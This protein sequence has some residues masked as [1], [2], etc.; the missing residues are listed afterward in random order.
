MTG[1]TDSTPSDLD[2]VLVPT[3]PAARP[4]AAAAVRR[5]DALMR[6]MAALS[7]AAA[8]VA[9]EVVVQ[10][11]LVACEA[12][13]A[14]ISVCSAD[15]ASSSMRWLATVG[16]LAALTGGSMAGPITPCADVVAAG[17][18]L[19][20]QHPARRY[21]ALG[22]GDLP[23]VQWLAVPL[24]REGRPCG[25]LWLAHHEAARQ[26]DAADVE[27]ATALAHVASV[28]LARAR[29]P[30]ADD[31]TSHETEERLR[32][33]TA[34]ADVGAWDFDPATG[35]LIWDAAVKRHFGLS[36]DATVHGYQTFLDGLH[37]EDRARVDAAVQAALLPGSPGYDITYRT[38]GLEDGE[39]RHIA[40]RGRA[41]F[42][43]AGRVVR[44]VGTTIDI[45]SR[46]AAS[47]SLRFLDALSVATQSAVAAADVMASTTRLLGQH[48]D[49]SRCAWADVDD[50]EETYQVRAEWSLAGAVV[51]D[52]HRLSVFGGEALAQLRAGR[53]LVV[54]HAE[55]EVS[56]PA[57]RD[58]FR[59][60]GIGAAIACPVLKGGRLVSL[61]VVHTAKPRRWTPAEVALLKAVTERSGAHIDRAR[62]EASLRE[63][64]ER[65]RLIGD[66]ANDAIWDW[67]LAT[68][69]VTW[70]RGLAKTFGHEDV[71][72][73]TDAA[74][75]MAHVH[76]DDR[77]HVK[78]HIRA[79]IDGEAATWEDEYRFQR[80][81]GSHAFVLDRGRIV[82]DAEGR[83]L[84]MVG[85]MQDLTERQRAARRL[86]ESEEFMRQLVE[87]SPDCI[88]VLDAEARL[89]SM[90]AFGMRQL[91]IDDFET[92]RGRD[93]RTF[94]SG[95]DR[96]AADRVFTEA[97]HG[98]SARF[99]GYCPTQRGE[100]RWWSVVATPLG[101][102]DGV[103]RVLVVSR[104]VTESHRAALGARFLA[105]ASAMLHDLSDS[106]ATLRRLARLAT[107]SFA[108][109]CV[110]DVV[111][112]A[113]KRHIDAR[114]AR[115]SRPD[116]TASAP[117]DDF[118]V[119]HVLQ[120]GEAELVEQVGEA[121]GRA[122][123]DVPHL[124][125]L[126]DLGIRSF[127]CVPLEVRTDVI[128]AMAFYI[129]DSE[130]NFTRVE[131]D[132]AV[133]LA[134]RV[135]IAIDNARLYRN[136]QDS[137]Q[138]KSEFLATL[139][140]ELRNPLAPIRTGLEVLARSG[141]QSPDGQ[142]VR[143]V[144]S[145][146]MGHMVR[147]VDDLLDVSRLSRGKLELKKCLVTLEEV[148]RDAVEGSQ[149]FFDAAGHRLTVVL[150]DVPV[151]L[152][153]DPTRLSQVVANLLTNA[154][155]YTP[156][157]GDIRVEA[158]LDGAHVAI[159]VSDTGIGLT[160]EQ[161]PVIF[162]MFGQIRTSANRT[163]G[164]LGIGLTLVRQLVE[165]HGG[166][167]TARS[168]GAQQ[169]S[170]FEVRLPVAHVVEPRAA[171]DV[172][173]APA[174][175]RA[176]RVLIVDDNDDSA[177]MLGLLV[178]MQGHDVRTAASGTD[179]LSVADA[180]APDVVFLDIGLPVMSGYE[181]AERLRLSETTAR[182]LLVALT[183][184][185]A[186]E[187][188]ER[189]RAAGF[190]LHMTKPVD[191]AEVERLLRDPAPT[192]RPV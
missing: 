143:A 168:A 15:E 133:D 18:P 91:A 65:Y 116:P 187:H 156:D 184:W 190:D 152:Y 165:M 47:D 87:H 169:G 61:V 125:Q 32:L 7:D 134:R 180:F 140:H 173:A 109:R 188:V 31:V 73:A 121:L 126:R 107:E 33:A 66:A 2:A 77:A 21:G 90:N 135:A 6:A 60:A 45:T 154:A 17:A 22:R 1:P 27:T 67:D 37:P 164:G 39:E 12:G 170:T 163:E 85:S 129:S 63:S 114:T 57:A 79:A 160:G 11:A 56:S 130:R 93:W 149:P 118:C 161:L 51:G 147:L 86:R 10:Q 64:E 28:L 142:R 76:P 120:T 113:D 75:W 151:Q 119:T 128:G 4:S 145:R 78:R 25:G 192:R 175:T 181:V 148:V 3:I 80:A 103:T 26:F 153:G 14:G 177:E 40:A 95:D 53:T 74:W 89:G 191:T 158:T 124:Q 69:V 117:C 104:D 122:S 92:V 146:Q 71:G 100:P 127:M 94:F 9:L 34:A 19:L 157:A 5:Q 98:R 62:V 123:G 72:T 46:Q 150:P 159:E 13:S 48:L 97:L 99:E 139:A 23:L 110:I 38:I 101:S 176:L 81:D 84:R 179:A 178:G 36:P 155:K 131:L 44:F 24:H 186:P 70:N 55:A 49:V 136:V 35:R 111:D 106:D 83:G 108:D 88:K 16:E 58:A 183:G 54:S 41:L 171:P 144:M 82:R 189:A 167:V 141:P 105:D 42:D 172:A 115:G 138:R 182:S 29:V 68:N 112:G 43:G 30:V 8:G 185:G 166:Q 52:V 174:E 50:G 102:A 96:V 59:A 20:L 162:E 132:V 137:D